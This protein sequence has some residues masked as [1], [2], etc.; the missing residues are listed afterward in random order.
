MTNSCSPAQA[1]D[2]IADNYDAMFTESIIGRAQRNA[3]WRELQRAFAP[4]QRVLEINCGTGIDALMLAQRGIAVD[5][6][7][8]SPRMIAV[9]KQRREHEFA[10]LG[11]SFRVL[12]AEDLR[13]LEGR[14]DGAFSNFGGLNC[15]PDLRCVAAELG[16]MVRPGGALLICLAGRFCAWELL[17]YTVQGRLRRAARRWIGHAE[18]KLRDG[19]SVPVFYPTAKQLC[20]EMSPWFHLTRRRGIA[21]MVPPSY[22]E[23]SLAARA[24][25]IRFA[26]RCD[27]ILG[28]IPAIRAMADHALFVFERTSA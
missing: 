22:A 20:R 12:A 2:L 25:F 21:V 15:V 10:G 1:F 24:P 18:G 27:R 16:R 17:W 9:A 7:D 28:R 23:N 26:E 11:L 13:Q 4:G 5:A 3:V 6:C 19:F 14:Y 8:V